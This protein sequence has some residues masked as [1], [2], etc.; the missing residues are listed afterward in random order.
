LKKIFTDRKEW[1]YLVPDQSIFTKGGNTNGL[2]LNLAAR[3][4]DGRWLMIY[5]GSRASFSVNLAKV[6]GANRVKAFWIDPRDARE[7][8]IGAVE[9]TG[10]R[11][12]STPHGWED[13]LLILE[14]TAG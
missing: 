7:V 4:K 13:A 11:A 10:E 9:N 12:F 3:H 1:C 14:A 2:V 8:S 6:G 5:L